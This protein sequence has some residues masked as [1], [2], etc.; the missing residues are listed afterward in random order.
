MKRNAFVYLGAIAGGSALVLSGCGSSDSSEAGGDTTTFKVAFNQTES[1]PQYRTL[2]EMGD[3]VNECTDGRYDLDVFANETLGGQKDTIEL[4]QAGSIEF[5]MVAGPLL[6]N[7][8]PDFVVFNLPYTFDSQ[9]HQRA[10][11]NDPEITGDLFASVE[12]QDISVMGAFHGGIRN[13]YNSEGPVNTPEDLNG[14]KIRVIESDTNIDMMELMGGS[15][16][17]MGQGDVYTAIQSGVITGGENNESIYANLKHAEVAPYYSYTRHLM[18]PDYLITNPAVMADL[19]E[20]D[21]ACF[22]DE[23]V[24]AI[25]DEAGYWAEEIETSIATAEAAGAEFNDA[26]VEAFRTALEPLIDSK[27]TNDVTRDIYEQVRAAAE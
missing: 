22:E 18:F 15:G 11:V 21:R 14:M 16:V 7:F 25:D 10:T 6:E 4:V 8:N 5:S 1:H 9:D 17:P 24:T 19:S 3:R 13:V 27:L 20:E 12:D 2:D 26:D 23:L